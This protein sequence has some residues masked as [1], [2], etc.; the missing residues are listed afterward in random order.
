M[1]GKLLKYDLR[2]TW[3]EFAGAYLA[4][5]L[6][7]LII[8]LLF[9]NVSNVLVSGIAGFLGVAVV[10]ATIVVMIIMLFR[11]YNINVFSKEGYLTMTLP[12]SS[13]QI[14]VSKLLISSLWI[15]LTGIVALLG[16]FIF[17]LNM[18]A[19]SLTE[20]AVAFGEMLSF[21]GSNGIFAIILMIIAV[22]LSTVK[23]IAKL[24]LA[25]SIAHIKQLNRFRIPAG[26]LSF[27]AFSWLEVFF[28]Q[29]LGWFTVRF[30]PVKE[31]LIPKLQQLE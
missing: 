16:F 19:V 3:R 31:E 30:I 2:S 6:S 13:P 27:F 22:I 1:L 12:V 4:I 26:I 29:F 15:I 18:R 9:R 8:P 10:I 20:I 11:I 14:L 25:C 7:V 5:L 23:E 24:F 21:I 28:I 17:L